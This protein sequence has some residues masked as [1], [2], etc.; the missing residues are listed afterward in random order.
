MRTKY[1]AVTVNYDMCM[2]VCKMAYGYTIVIDGKFSID[3]MGR[4]WWVNLKK[5][6]D[7]SSRVGHRIVFRR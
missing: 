1:R 3:V 7:I 5:D 4:K 6:G 2:N